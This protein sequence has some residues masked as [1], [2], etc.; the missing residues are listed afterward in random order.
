MDRGTVNDTNIGNGVK[1]DHMCHI[2]HNSIIGDGSIIT[3]NVTL[4]GS[5][6]IGKN[7]WIGAGSKILNKVTVGNNA[8]IGLGTIVIK[9]VPENAV[10]VG[11]PGKII[12][13]GNQP[14]M[15]I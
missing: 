8:Y 4:C 6:R 10:V 1:I 12:R 13:I 5:T 11:N 7:V 2:G 15:V 9:D 14:H 3:A